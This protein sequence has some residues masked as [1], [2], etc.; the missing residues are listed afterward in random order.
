MS[1]AVEQIRPANFEKFGDIP[2]ELREKARKAVDVH[3]SHNGKR[4]VYAYTESYR[5]GNGN[6][7]TL[8]NAIVDSSQRVN[9]V[10]LHEQWSYHKEIT[11]GGDIC[12]SVTEVN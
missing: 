1:A 7:I 11:F 3:N 5:V 8:F 10:V 2:K 6:T 9:G 12:F 4:L